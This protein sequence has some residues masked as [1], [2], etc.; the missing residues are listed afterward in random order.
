MGALSFCF[1]NKVELGSIVLN[2][3][4][5]L[6][7]QKEETKEKSLQGVQNREDNNKKLEKVIFE[8]GEKKK[9]SL[10]RVKEVAGLRELKVQN[11]L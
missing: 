10:R 3:L 4:V 7:F 2:T 1:C 8:Q 6:R 11:L 9:K 5:Q